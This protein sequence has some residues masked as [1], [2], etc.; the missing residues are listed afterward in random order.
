[1][2]MLDRRVVVPWTVGVDNSDG[3]M[4]LGAALS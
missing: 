3:F 4:T 2:L 1:M